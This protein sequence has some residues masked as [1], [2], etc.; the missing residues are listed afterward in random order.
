LAP[1][2]R[3]P[4]GGEGEK[5]PSKA[6]FDNTPHKPAVPKK[7]TPLVFPYLPW[8]VVG[9]E[10]IAI[11]LEW[12]RTCLNDGIALNSPS[13]VLPVMTHAAFASSRNIHRG[14]CHRGLALP[15]SLPP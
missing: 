7:P 10:K 11:C 14:A 5:F 8:I 9:V 12:S 2:D 3:R 15:A 6:Y 1:G 4:E 13:L